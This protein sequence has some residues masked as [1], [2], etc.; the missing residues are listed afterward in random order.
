MRKPQRTERQPKFP[1]SVTARFWI[2]PILII[3]SLIFAQALKMPVSYMIFIFVLLLP[4]GIAAQLILAACF[5]HTSVRASSEAVEKRTS[6]SVFCIISNSCPLPF[7]FIEAELLTPDERGARCVPGRV[8]FSLAPL[9]GCELQ[10]SAEFAFRGEY[11]VGLSRLWVYDCFRM[12]KLRLK[13]ENYAKILVYPRR[14]ELPPKPLSGESERT[15]QITIRQRG[16]DNTELSDIRNYIKGDS[17]KSIHWKLSSKSQELI[18]KDYSRNAGNSVYI[19]CDLE[20]HYAADP[21]A[22]P[23]RPLPEYAD[24]IDNLNSDLVVEHCLAAAM[25]ELRALNTVKLLWFETVRGIASPASCTISSLADFDA[26]FRRFASAPLAARADQPSLL[27][28][29]ITDR[30][31]SSLIFVTSCLDA[32][33]M[34]QYVSLAA[35]N[36][37]MGAKNIEFMY[38]ADD[39]F[40]IPDPEAERCVGERLAELAAVMELTADNKA[41]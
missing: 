29:L 24:I 32:A 26:A 1:L 2:Y 39:S 19:I 33:A 16:S 6:V 36:R 38:C 37:G 12:V 17:L 23:R 10:R 30:G 18:V 28:S 25:R 35:A 8:G 34:S 15:A 3:A 41:G 20:P 4:V 31:D 40:Y 5:I 11:G 13:C 21:E 7:P 22:Q 27:A 9:S 14:Y